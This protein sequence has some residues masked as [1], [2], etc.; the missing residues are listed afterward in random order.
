MIMKRSLL[1][2]LLCWVASSVAF[3]LEQVEGVY[4]IG[5]AQDL[6]AFSN[7]VAS[8]NGSISG[9]L[10]ADIDMTDVTFSPIGSTNSKFTGEFNGQE[11][12]IKNLILESED[13]EYVGLFGVI[14]GG[15]Y[16]HD[17]VIA[18]SCKIKGKAF[19]GGIAGGTNGGGTATFERCGNEATITAIEQNAAGICGVSMGSQCGIVI[20]NCFNTAGIVADREAAAFCGWVGDNGSRIENSYN[21]GYVIGQDGNYSL[22]RNTRGKGLNNYDVSGNQ[23]TKISDDSYD[24]ECG[25]VCYQLNGS[26]SDA[27]IWFQTIDKD[28]HPYP[29]ASRGVVYAVGDLFCD[30]TPKDENNFSFSNNNESNRDPHVFEDG[31]CTKCDAVDKN[32]KALTEDG[33]YLL[34]TAKDLNWFAALVNAGNKKVNARLAA[35]IDFTA[36]TQDDIMI[37]GDAFTAEEEDPARAFTGI[38]DGAGHTITIDYAASYDGVGL[39]K[40]VDS[41]TIKNLMVKGS[42]ETSNRFAGG[43]MFVTRG[44]STFENIVVDVDINGSYVGDATHGGICAVAHETPTFS[45]CAFIGSMVAE[46]CEGSAAIIGYAHGEVETII[47]NCYV[48]PSELLLANGSTVI[49]RHVKTKKNCFYTDNVIS[50]SDNSVEII[51]EDLLATGELCYLLNAADGIDAWRQDLGTDNY[52]VP[53]ADHKMVYVAGSES[54]DGTLKP[55]V[56]YTNTETGVTRD[57][58]NYENDICTVCGARIIRNA[59]QLEAL[60][61]AINSGEIDGKVIVDVVEDIDMSDIA[62]F[63]GIGTR[64]TELTGEVDE[65]QNP[66]TRD[67]KRPFSGIFDGHGHK[68]SHMNIDVQT[69]NVG[70]FGLASGATIKNIIVDESCEIWSTGYSAGIVGTACGNGTLTIENCGNEATVN[71]GPDGANGAGILGVNDLSEAY[72]RIINCYN[73]GTITGQRECGAISGWLGDVAEVVNC[74][75]SGFVNPEAIDGERS[76]V[77]Y[78]GN[79][80]KLVN[81]YEVEGTQV[82]QVTL[83]DVESGKLCFLLNKD[84]EAPIFFQTLGTD[85]YPVFDNTHAVVYET[86]DGGYS[87]DASASGIET[88]VV[89]KKSGIQ[90]V[91]SLSGAR[92]MQLQR[93]INIVRMADGSVKK[94]MK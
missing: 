10:T 40:V 74:W 92:Q 72:V 78:N 55:D 51:S 53:F 93:G 31:I 71:V 26:Q 85:A 64:A 3:A 77:R 44:N 48:A 82:N 80:V 36:Y 57:E 12:S 70:L 23:G 4:Q 14:G 60:A 73:T 84:A 62:D 21:A 61:D 43:L 33:F 39:F 7:M 34:E 63:T 81:C 30:G 68:I 32:Y 20:L 94:I 11:H 1:F 6:V 5:T 41:S 29:F 42:I 24:M 15:A 66:I 2:A 13:Q 52:P 54:C 27:P 47:K 35:D 22:W 65:Q 75:N 17:V 49:A 76:F 37:G 59:T 9:A 50:V 18:K 46:G 89:S 58:H 38:F 69:G 83:D 25:A 45:N 8:G 19:V 91:Y 67:V 56:T 28:P 87:N 88:S 90:V 79:N 16:I 86:V